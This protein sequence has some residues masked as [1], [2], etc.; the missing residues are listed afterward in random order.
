MKNHVLTRG[1]WIDDQL[2]DPPVFNHAGGLVSSGF[3]LTVSGPQTQYV[4]ARRLRSP[5]RG[6]LPGGDG[7]LR[8]RSPSPRT[9]W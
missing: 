5:R 9:P 7:L 4:T 2:I 8:A 6:R 1:E 3:Q